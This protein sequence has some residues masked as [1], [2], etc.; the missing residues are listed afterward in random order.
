MSSCPHEAITFIDGK[1]VTD[2]SH[3]DNCFDCV[4]TCPQ[5]ALK[6]YGRK[7][8]V[9]EAVS[10]IAKDEIFFF[11][12]GGGV[13]ISGGECLLQ[14][15]FTTAI[16]KACRQRGINTAVETS[17]FSPWSQV[18]K[19]VPH[20]NHI[21]VDIKHPK[22]ENHADLCGVSNK[23]IL[24]NLKKLDESPNSFSLHIRI[25]LIPS[26]ND[27]E[28]TL[29]ES[30]HFCASLNKLTEVEFLPYHRLGVASYKTLD[31][32]Y[33]LNHIQTPSDQYLKRKLA[34]IESLNPPF[35]VKCGAGYV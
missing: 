14:A 30:L 1:P 29:T 15:E 9:R 32:P 28:V 2:G 10:E 26:I 6:G 22:A 27:S 8:S 33:H 20:L 24:D 11:H 23:V 21:Y 35:R 18:E 34:F 7:M 12:S 19:M 13:T 17:L 3:C 25:P 16:L 4:S 31:F 5:E